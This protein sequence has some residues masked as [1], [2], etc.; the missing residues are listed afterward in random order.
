M[1][2]GLSGACREHINCPV[3]FEHERGAPEGQTEVLQ[4]VRKMRFEAAYRRR[5]KDRFKMEFDL[6]K[7]VV[8]A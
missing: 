4:E 8:H 7:S 6:L 2:I 3:L 1:S 5:Q